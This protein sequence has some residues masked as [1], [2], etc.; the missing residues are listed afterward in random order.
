MRDSEQS[1]EPV[2]TQRATRITSDESLQLRVHG[3]P[4]LPALIHLPG[5]HGD[6]NLLGPF[7]AALGGRARFVE[8]TYPRR[9]DWSLDDYAGAVEAALIEH[10]ITSG[11][12]LGE[13]F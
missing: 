11:W 13:S 2:S 9:L 8:S 7:R 4:S 5:L 1:A 12:I 10:G 3:D 6:W